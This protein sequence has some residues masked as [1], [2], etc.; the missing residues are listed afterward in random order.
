MIE[1]EVY[2][3]LEEVAPA[4][5]TILADVYPIS[6]WTVEQLAAD[7]K[8]PEVVYY[9]AKEGQDI[10]GF[11]AVQEMVDELEILQIAVRTDVQRQ[12]I[13]GRL[14]DCLA[15]FSGAVFLEVRA[16]NQPAKRL[17]ERYG[18]IEIGRRKGYY[19]SPVGDAIV[20]KREK[21][22]R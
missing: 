8:R 1:I 12:G 17:Y 16:S 7:M 5:H 19:H 14:L 11:L 10:L 20:M 13:A 6:P 2:K 4:L 3:G 22:E 9:L 18:F 21:D 15:P